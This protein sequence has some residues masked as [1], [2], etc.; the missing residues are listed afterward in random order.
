ML[1]NLMTCNID[2]MTDK[3]DKSKKFKEIGKRRVNN[4]VKAISLIGNLGNKSQYYSTERERE[5]IIKAI[6][7]AVK[8]M[9]VDLQ[10]KN[11]NVDEAFD[12]E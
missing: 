8:Q 12:W 7:K 5:Q 11:R 3:N 9:K 10:K 4:A 6:D 2:T 1:Y